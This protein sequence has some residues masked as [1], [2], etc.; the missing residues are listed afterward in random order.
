[1]L[2][3]VNPRYIVSFLMAIGLAIIGVSPLTHHVMSGQSGSNLTEQVQKLM[4]I[5]EYISYY[6]ASGTELD[7]L[8]FSP[9]NYRIQALDVEGALAAGISQDIVDLASEIVASQNEIVTR[10]HAWRTTGIPRTKIDLDD[11]PRVRELHNKATA[12]QRR[13]AEGSRVEGRVEGSSN[14]VV[15]AS[16]SHPCG[17][18]DHP[19]P[20]HNPPRY[21]YT[22]DGETYFTTN[23]YHETAGY[24]GGYG[25]V[26]YTKGRSY[27]G[28]YGY[29]SSPRF[30]NHGLI[31]GSNSYSIQFGEPNPEVLSYLWP[32]LELGMVC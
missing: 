24:A 18:Y 20:D 1:M 8:D 11:Y 32:L 29:C 15:F 31:G 23:G 10:W 7:P 28:A 5:E 27:S 25:G 26:D 21:Q 30:R 16:S 6:D 2:R 13:R 14:G 22:G 3:N 12:E 9:D 19:V 17:N 4:L